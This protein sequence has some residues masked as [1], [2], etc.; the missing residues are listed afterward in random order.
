MLGEGSGGGRRGTA[1]DGCEWAGL[2][3]RTGNGEGW[4]GL[5]AIEVNGEFHDASLMKI[6]TLFLWR[7]VNN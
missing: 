4:R 3:Q 1:W 7:I 6:L 2:L 5:L